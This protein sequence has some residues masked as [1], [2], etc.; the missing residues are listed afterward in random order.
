MEHPFIIKLHYAFQTSKK[1]YFVFDFVEGGELWFHMK[2]ENR[3]KERKARFYSAQILLALEC[4]H[5]EGFMYRDLKPDNI[6]ID[7]D[8]N[9][10]LMDF[11]LS[12]SEQISY[13]FCGTP[14]YL[15]PEIFSGEGY[16]RE[17]D[18][19]GFGLVLVEM[20]TGR[21][22]IKK[23]RFDRKIMFEKI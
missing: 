6:M 20:I 15:S 18:F 13:D 10:K 14:E 22:P 4:L 23:F 21:H 16:G 9:I 7:K 19:W 8:G 17:I 12:T 3:L 5:R 11:G 1:L 2:Q